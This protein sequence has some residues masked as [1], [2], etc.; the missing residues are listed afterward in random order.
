MYTH[1]YIY[2]YTQK[3]SKFYCVEN[4]TEGYNRLHDVS[5]VPSFNHK[6]HVHI[7]IKRLL[8][9]LLIFVTSGNVC[10]VCVCVRA[11]ACVCFVVVV[12]L[13]VCVCVWGGGGGS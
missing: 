6:T 9:A 2:I 4:K 1:V 11:R 3:L 7:Q 13:C 5:Q 10:G 8:W 12:V